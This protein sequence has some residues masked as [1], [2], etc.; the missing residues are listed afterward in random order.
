MT[1]EIKSASRVLDMLEMFSTRCDGMTLTEVSRGLGLP[2]SSTLGLL[3]TLHVRGYLLREAD[4]V[5]RLN[6]IV[7]RDGFA[8]HGR[9]LRVGPPVMRA[10]ANDIGETVILGMQGAV[11]MVR[12]IAKEAAKREVRFDIE[13][14]RQEPA[15]C[16]AIGL[17][18][19]ATQ[20]DAQVDKALAAM[21]R[22]Q[23]TECTVTDEAAI[24]ARIAEVR[25]SGVAVVE[26]GLVTGATGIATLI[27]LSS[28]QPLAAL[29]VGCVSARF[30]GNRDRIVAALREAAKAIGVAMQPDRAA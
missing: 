30:P 7:R 23:L 16:T 17:A 10:L 3:R 13:L 18:L 28:H 8:R 14:P 19:L 24:R 21:P 29:N 5:Y 20:D 6:D 22:E 26:D 11:G 2:K 4:D 25:S 12:L 9:L 15:Y 27:P 1:D